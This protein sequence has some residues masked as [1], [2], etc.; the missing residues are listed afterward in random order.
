LDAE[1]SVR[2][3]GRDL[4]VSALSLIRVVPMMN[5]LEIFRLDE[6]PSC[7][8]A[9]DPR[10]EEDLCHRCEIALHDVSVAIGVGYEDFAYVM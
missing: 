6:C 3:Q 2:F 1:E 5:E 8:V 9:L 10:Y 7:S 4:L